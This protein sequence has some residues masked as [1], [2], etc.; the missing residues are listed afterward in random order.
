MA[1][2]G[3]FS[4]VQL[5]TPAELLACQKEK[6]KN[7]TFFRIYVVGVLYNRRGPSIFWVDQSGS[8]KKSTKESDSCGIQKSVW[9]A[10]AWFFFCISLLY[11]SF[12][13]L[14]KMKQ[15]SHYSEWSCLFIYLFYSSAMAEIK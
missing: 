13:T 8:E 11:H 2:N 10:F 1:Y 4:T 5:P 7:F 15:C 12:Y 3:L 9:C 6:D 14:N